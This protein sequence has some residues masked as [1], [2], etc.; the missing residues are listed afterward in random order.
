MVYKGNMEKRSERRPAR[1]LRKVKINYA[2]FR[3]LR[4]Y[5]PLRV[6]AAAV[7]VSEQHLSQV[8]RGVKEPSADLLLRM[9]SYH[10]VD[11]SD[12]SNGAQAGA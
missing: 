11:L 1:N 7:G 5:T 9:C 2:R 3:E 8:E 10:K 4:G 12:V 6:V